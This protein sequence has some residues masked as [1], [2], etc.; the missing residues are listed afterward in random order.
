MTGYSK[1]ADYLFGMPYPISRIIEGM[2]IQIPADVREGMTQIA[3]KF[4]RR[5]ASGSKNMTPE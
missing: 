1:A 2:A 4:G 3:R 5:A